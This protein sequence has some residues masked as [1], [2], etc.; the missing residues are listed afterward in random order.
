[1]ITLDELRLTSAL[2]VGV[3]S[4]GLLVGL[5]CVTLFPVDLPVRLSVSPAPGG[6]VVSLA[7]VF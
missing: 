7:G 5:L 6:G 2:L 3:G 4:A 1:M